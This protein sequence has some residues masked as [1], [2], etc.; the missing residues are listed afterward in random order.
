MPFANPR[1]LEATDW[2]R[3]ECLPSMIFVPV[4]RLQLCIDQCR[5][6]KSE[7]PPATMAHISSRAYGECN[8]SAVLSKDFFSPRGEMGTR[9]NP[10][11]TTLVQ[12]IYILRRTAL[13]HDL[14]VQ[15]SSLWHY[16]QVLCCSKA[17]RLAAALACPS[18][19]PAPTSHIYIFVPLSYAL[20]ARYPTGLC[21]CGKPVLLVD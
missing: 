8:T 9:H 2:C 19:T 1:L 15:S 13:P 17:E 18:S 7:T 5:R 16:L 12:I 20:W 14:L 10:E 4:E 3:L 21:S 11:H 6:M